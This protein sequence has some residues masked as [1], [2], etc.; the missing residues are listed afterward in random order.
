MRP[1]RTSTARLLTSTRPP[2]TSTPTNSLRG[3]RPSAMGGR[4]YGGAARSDHVRKSKRSRAPTSVDSPGRRRRASTA[5]SA[6]SNHRRDWRFCWHDVFRRAATCGLRG[7][8]AGKCGCDP[9]HKTLRS[10]PF[11]VAIVDHLPGG[12]LV[13]GVRADQAEPYEHGCRPPRSLDLQVNLLT[14]RETT[15]IIQ[16]LDRV[17]VHLG[18]EQHHDA[19]SREIGQHNAHEHPGAVHPLALHDELKLAFGQGRRAAPICSNPFSGA[20]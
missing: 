8:D 10:F 1:Q 20:Q 19:D 18:I 6:R 16:M 7:L 4:F 3:D 13:D 17:S 15:R 11:S 2:H 9:R 12:G 5:I 14:E